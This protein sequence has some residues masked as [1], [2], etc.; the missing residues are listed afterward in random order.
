MAYEA[1]KKS[2][3]I[4]NLLQLNS[5]PELAPTGNTSFS[6]SEPSAGLGI[7]LNIY[8]FALSIIEDI[9]TLFCAA[10]CERIG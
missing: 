4:L 5:V 3:H 2:D 7:N 10:S 6:A 1:G 8:G 9:T